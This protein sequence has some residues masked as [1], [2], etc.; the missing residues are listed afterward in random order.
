MPRCRILAHTLTS[1]AIHIANPFQDLQYASCLTSLKRLLVSITSTK[2]SQPGALDQ[3]TAQITQITGLK[4]LQ[5][6]GFPHSSTQSISHELPNLRVLITNGFGP[7]L[8]VQR[9]TQLRS[10]FICKGALTQ[11]YL[12]AGQTCCLE[13]L[14]LNISSG[15]TLSNL[16]D[17]PRLSSLTFV[18]QCPSNL[19]NV[20]TSIAT[21]SISASAWPP[22]PLLYRLTIGLMPC[23]PPAVWAKYESLCELD[24]RSYHHPRLPSWFA[25]LTLLTKLTLASS[26]LKEFPS[27]LLKLTQLQEIFL[28]MMVFPKEIVQF[29]SFRHLSRLTLHLDHNVNVSANDARLSASQESV[30]GLQATL[31]KR[32]PSASVRIVAEG[33]GWRIELK[34]EQTL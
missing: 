8:D 29:A 11:L 27:S 26:S 4:T 20:Q 14:V 32:L 12:P 15:Y 24:L 1:L 21:S 17:A 9:C 16:G 5:L 30:Y 34:L 31:L 25:D 3:V 10:L 22:L 28:C 7:M 2:A 23:A 33:S 6:Y 18:D 13:Q 19:V